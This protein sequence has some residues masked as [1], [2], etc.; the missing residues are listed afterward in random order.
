M[1]GCTRVLLVELGFEKP[2]F[3]FHPCSETNLGCLP[4]LGLFPDPHSLILN[5][6][7]VV[8]DLLDDMVVQ[9]VEGSLEHDVGEVRENTSNG[10]QQSCG[11]INGCGCKG[12]EEQLMGIRRD[13]RR[14]CTID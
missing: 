9:W 14:H 4:C 7:L 8:L 11:P 2:D 3:G 1:V 12:F 6:L 5:I 13:G 10:H